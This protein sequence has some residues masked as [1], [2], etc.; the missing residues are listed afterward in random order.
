MCTGIVR[1]TY[2]MIKGLGQLQQ[3]LL[4]TLPSDP[5]DAMTTTTLAK[6]RDRQDGKYRY[7]NYDTDDPRWCDGSDVKY[8]RRSIRRA[9]DSLEKRGLVRLGYVTVDKDENAD[10]GD[11]RGWRALA[12]W[13][14]DTSPR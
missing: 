13:K 9:L 1:Y 11:M 5:K 3:W 4:D 6:L 2:G 14:V 8:G 7:T 10:V 12:A